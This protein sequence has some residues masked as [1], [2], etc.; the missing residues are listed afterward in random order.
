MLGE[1]K[2]KGPKGSL[3]KGE[4]L[5]YVGRIHSLKDLKARSILP[6]IPS[7]R[8]SALKKKKRSEGKKTL[9]ALLSTEGRVVGPC[10][11][12]L[13]P[14][15][16]KGLVDSLGGISPLHEPL[17][18]RAKRDPA[19]EMLYLQFLLRKSVSVGHV[20]RN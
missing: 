14:K 4:V 5:A 2:P 12:K 18:G 11:E 1:L 8:A 17:H 19:A 7:T 20:G 3:R 16:P 15:G 13:N 6:S 10:W 9:S